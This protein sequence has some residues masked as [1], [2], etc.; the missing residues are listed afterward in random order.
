MGRA[1]RLGRLSAEQ[2]ALPGHL[3]GWFGRLRLVISSR[4]V[5]TNWRPL[6]GEPGYGRWHE[7]CK[8]EK[9]AAFRQWRSEDGGRAR[10]ACVLGCAF[11]LVTVLLWPWY[12]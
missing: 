3:H 1:A 4:P 11:M 8:D 10:A 12:E 6:P 9:L 2:H 7:M 5:W